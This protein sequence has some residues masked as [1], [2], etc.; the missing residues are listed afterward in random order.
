MQLALVLTARNSAFA[1]LWQKMAP[2]TAVL[3]GVVVCVDVCEEVGV[4]VAVD[5]AVVVGVVVGDVVGV[6]MEH[7][8]NVPSK[9]ESNAL[10]NHETACSHVSSV[11]VLTKPAKE[12]N[13]SSSPVASPE[14]L[15]NTMPFNADALAAS[16]QRAMFVSCTAVIPL[17]TASEHPK[18]PRTPV[19]VLFD[20]EGRRQGEQQGVGPRHRY[21]LQAVLQRNYS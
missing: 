3:V 4:V 14:L 11:S 18:V 17:P 6:V 21:E 19:P 5:V 1:V 10:F 7:C 9:Y 16:L 8:V 2:C 13:T 15:L 20:R 12:H